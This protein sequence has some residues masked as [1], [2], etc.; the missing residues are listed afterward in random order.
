[1]TDMMM[2]YHILTLK[3]CTYMY[4]KHKMDW[5]MIKYRV[6]SWL[7]QYQKNKTKVNKG[8]IKIVVELVT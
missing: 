8:N 3:L 4:E 5:N 2:N 7:C 6:A 1:M